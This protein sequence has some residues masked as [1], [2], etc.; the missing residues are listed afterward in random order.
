MQLEDYLE[1]HTEPVEYIRIKG[2]RI[3]LD[4]VLELYNLGMRPEQIATHFGCPLEPVQVYAAI[5][6][7]L[8]NK[9]AVEAYLERGERRWKETEAAIRAQPESEAVK[10]IKAIKAA[11]AMASEAENP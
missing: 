2:S 10:R 7:Y 5:A 11:R 4:L 1:F 3:S 8:Q 6:Y 9:E